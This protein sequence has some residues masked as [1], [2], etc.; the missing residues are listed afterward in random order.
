MSV[1]RE[2]THDLHLPAA[3]FADVSRTMIGPSLFLSSSEK[4]DPQIMT[5]SPPVHQQQQALPGDSMTDDNT[6]ST[7]QLLQQQRFQNNSQFSASQRTDIDGMPLRNNSETPPQGNKNYFSV[8]ELH[9]VH[10]YYTCI[11][12]IEHMISR[13]IVDIALGRLLNIRIASWSIREYTIAAY[14]HSII[15]IT[16]QK[17]GNKERSL[18]SFYRARECISCPGL[19][20]TIGSNFELAVAL[21][22]MASIVIVAK[23]SLRAAAQFY[24]YCVLLF[25]EKSPVNIDL[26]QSS[27]TS[28][29][30]WIQAFYSARLPYSHTQFLAL[31][32]SFQF[33]NILSDTMQTELNFKMDLRRILWN[34]LS[35]TYLI[36]FVDIT[37]NRMEENVRVLDF[38]GDIF[39]V[40]NMDN[41]LHIIR[42]IMGDYHQLLVN[43][44]LKFE[45]EILRDG[46]QMDYLSQLEIRLR[47]QYPVHDP[48]RQTQ[49]HPAISK[50]IQYKR[51]IADIMVHRIEQN[52][53]AL[54]LGNPSTF[55]GILSMIEVQASFD[56]DTEVLQFQ[57]HQ[58]LLS[59]LLRRIH[60]LQT[61]FKTLEVLDQRYEIVEEKCQHL[62]TLLGMQKDRVQH[63]LILMASTTTMDASS[64]ALPQIAGVNSREDALVSSQPETQTS[65]AETVAGGINIPTERDCT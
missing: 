34:T 55:Q 57:D 61:I 26:E 60:H 12:V 4:D 23:E 63:V 40:D 14:I 53:D 20:E 44:T 22:M 43:P 64:T 19:L 7:E 37:L 1:S 35:L 5:H 27:N 21:N 58:N 31:K 8:E 16:F 48:Q 15:S 3:V 9:M 11:P 10:L 62:V 13:D 49:D 42:K 54:Y 24:Q 41:C 46:I 6:S 47:N 2:A 59:F 18:L 25:I 36:N 52:F 45:S 17:L 33:N 51:Q 39:N 38:L 56:I 32:I 30:Q 29:E 65:N 28:F 50:I